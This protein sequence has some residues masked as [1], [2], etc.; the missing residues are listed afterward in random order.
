MI[1]GNFFKFLFSFFKKRKEYPEKL[2]P[3]NRFDFIRFDN[4]LYLKIWKQRKN[5]KTYSFIFNSP[6]PDDK[7]NGLNYISPHFLE[8]KKITRPGDEEFVIDSVQVHY[9]K[10]YYY[11]IIA[12]NKKKSSTIIWVPINSTECGNYYKEYTLE[13]GTKLTDHLKYTNND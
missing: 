9:Y 3:S 2:E 8:G 1:L 11:H 7:N 12:T 6:L 10:G 5:A 13:D 4:D